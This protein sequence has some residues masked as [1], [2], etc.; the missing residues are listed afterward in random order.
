MKYGDTFNVVYNTT[1]N[2]N[3][4]VRPFYVLKRVKNKI[5]MV[6][7]LVLWVIYDIT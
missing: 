7:C 1:P 5:I 6:I 2:N 4:Y 3:T